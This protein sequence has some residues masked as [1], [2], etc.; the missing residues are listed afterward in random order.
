MTTVVL[1]IIFLLMLILI[2]AGL[3]VL[4]KKLNT[5][6]S[7]TLFFIGAGILI[8]PLAIIVFILF[9]FAICTL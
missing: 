7:K 9:C 4:Y 1:F 6:A 3:R 8:F 2:I 5:P